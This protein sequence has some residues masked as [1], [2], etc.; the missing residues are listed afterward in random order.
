MNQNKYTLRKLLVNSFIVTV[1]QVNNTT[2]SFKA[3]TQMTNQGFRVKAEQA[4]SDR[5]S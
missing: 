5:F 4:G 3:Q 2:I 1:G